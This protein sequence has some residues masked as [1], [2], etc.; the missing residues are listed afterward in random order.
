MK[1]I[2]THAHLQSEEFNAILDDVINRLGIVEKVFLAT[3][4]VNDIKKACEITHKYDN[5]YFFAG[6]HPHY[7]N[8]FKI[9]D[10]DI[11]E[12]YLKD[13]KC[14]G[15]GEIGLDYFYNYAPKDTQKTLFSNLLDLAIY[16]NKWVSIHIRDA[17]KDA[18]DIL[19]TK[20]NLKAIIHCFNGDLDLLKLALDKNYLLGIGGIVTF[21]NSLIRQNITNVPL[22][23]MVLETDAPYLAPVP[24]RSKTN[25]PSFLQYTLNAL[26]SLVGA[27]AEEIAQITY[28][29]SLR[30]LND[31]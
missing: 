15:I 10:L 23:N 18:I 30:V 16:H 26:C 25:E 22:K 9:G 20:N 2:D 6:I 21:K 17:T 8:E 31:K 24:K 1:I 5:L 13:E 7:A 29:N 12:N 4:Y 3:S 11:I 28:S 27:Q 14:I 19:S